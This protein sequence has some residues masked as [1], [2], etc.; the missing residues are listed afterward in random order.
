[1]ANVSL[2]L[3]LELSGIRETIEAIRE[4]EPDIGRRLNKTIREALRVTERGAQQKYPNGAW[5]IRINKKALFGELVTA[6]GVLNPK[7]WGGSSPGAKANV[8]EFIGSTYSGDREQVKGLIESLN[9]RYA[10][11]SEGGRFV[12]GAWDERGKLE[13]AKIRTAVKDA[14]RELQRRMDAAGEVY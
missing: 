1:M 11:I 7:D 14:E 9:D 2:D 12:F 13:L 8:F 6:P 3:K 5:K 10:N 4:T